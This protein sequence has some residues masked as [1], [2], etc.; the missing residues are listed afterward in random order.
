[1]GPCGRSNKYKKVSEGRL[2]LKELVFV[3]TQEARG[4]KGRNLGVVAVFLISSSSSEPAAGF[5]P[6]S[7]V[8][9]KG[10]GQDH[11][12]TGWGAGGVDAIS[13]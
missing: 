13:P 12:G 2:E 10:L 11:L 9:W 1:M 3:F 6:Q 7:A 5:A 8:D 4:G